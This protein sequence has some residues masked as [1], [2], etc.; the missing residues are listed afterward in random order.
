MSLT[1]ENANLVEKLLNQVQEAIP[2]MKLTKFDMVN[3]IVKVRNA[4]LTQRELSA[5]ERDFFDPVKA[6][7]SA[8]L[9][10]KRKQGMGEKIDIEILLNERL[11]LKKRRST[12]PKLSGKFKGEI[13]VKGSND[14]LKR[15]LQEQRH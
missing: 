2:N 7:E 10:A 1:R 11:L 9:D 4:K 12:K 15:D 14:C 3:W 6:L 13:Q 5:I 8:I